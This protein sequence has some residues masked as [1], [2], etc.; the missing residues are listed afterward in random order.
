[1]LKRSFAEFH[2][3]RAAPEAREA[4]AAGEAAL[5]ALRAWP[6]PAS[7][8]GTGRPEVER[9]VALTRRVESLGA[10]LQARLRPAPPQRRGPPLRARRACSRCCL[11]P[12]LPRELRA[13][14]C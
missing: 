13:C 5:A 11:R 3:Q 8:R 6:W 7:R 9:Y 2:A 12:W 1:M 4:L 10:L 14:A